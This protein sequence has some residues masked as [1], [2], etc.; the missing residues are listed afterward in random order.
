MSEK[1]LNKEKEYLHS[2]VSDNYLAL[3]MALS[4]SLSCGLNCP[5]C[6]STLRV[7]YATNKRELLSCDTKII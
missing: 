5:Y 2:H 3:T 6:V 1:H 4:V 7:T